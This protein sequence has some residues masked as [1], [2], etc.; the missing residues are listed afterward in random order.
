MT[1]TQSSVSESSA[2][3]NGGGTIAWSAVLAATRTNGQ[4]LC[5]SLDTMGA[6]DPEGLRPQWALM[7]ERLSVDSRNRPE[8]ESKALYLEARSLIRKLLFS[9]P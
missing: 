7:T 6:E 1:A 3:P 9:R 2:A 5:D 8:A 4:A